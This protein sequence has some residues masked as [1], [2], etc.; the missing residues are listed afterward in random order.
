MVMIRRHEFSDL[1]AS[2]VRSLNVVKVPTADIVEGSIGGTI[3]KPI[4]D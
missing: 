1:P 2:L 3:N 4:V